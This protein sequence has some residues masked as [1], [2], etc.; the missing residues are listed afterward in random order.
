MHEVLRFLESGTPWQILAAV[1][2]AAIVAL[3]RRYVAASDRL[4]DLA[5]QQTRGYT[6]VHDAIVRIQDDLTELRRQ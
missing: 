2:L 4:F 3:W 1:L 5:I 6:R